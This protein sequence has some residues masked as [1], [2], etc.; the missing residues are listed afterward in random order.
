[1]NAKQSLKAARKH[2]EELEDWNGKAKRDIK[3]YNACIDGV[4]AG[5]CSFCDWCEENRLGECD[6]PE[7]G[8]G[9]GTWWLM[10]NPVVKIPEEGS[11]EENDSKGILSASP[12]G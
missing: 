7:K 4:I 8:T 2:I 5:K 1:M 6:R 3:A 12:V 10:E 11:D 9:C